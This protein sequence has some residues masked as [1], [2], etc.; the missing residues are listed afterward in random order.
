MLGIGNNAQ[1]NK[2]LLKR[3]RTRQLKETSAKSSRAE[4][5]KASPTKAELSASKFKKSTQRFKD[6]KECPTIIATEEDFKDPIS[7][8]QKIWKTH[9][10]GIAKII[11][12][13]NWSNGTNRLFVDKLLPKLNQSVS[14]LETRIQTLNQLFSGKVSLGFNS[15]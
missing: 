2:N 11:P 12:P 6:V 10:T 8:F 3:K 1:I 7:F 14:T 13:E 9:K 4:S 5:T 15:L